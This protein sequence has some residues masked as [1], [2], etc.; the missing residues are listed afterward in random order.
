MFIF[1]SV[2]LRLNSIIWTFYCVDLS[3]AESLW[4]HFNVCH[5]S[6]TIELWRKGPWWL[7]KGDLSANFENHWWKVIIYTPIHDKKTKYV[8]MIFLLISARIYGSILFTGLIFFL[9]SYGLGVVA[10]HLVV[11]C[12]KYF[13]YLLESHISLF[14]LIYCWINWQG[15]LLLIVSR[16]PWVEFQCKC[17]DGN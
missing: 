7:V 3:L 1:A 9:M 10:P 6:L 15:P 11:L 12:L 2:R 5:H 8:S 16:G 4:Q 17:F 13:T 14:I